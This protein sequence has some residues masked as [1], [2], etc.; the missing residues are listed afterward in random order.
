M[1]REKWGCDKPCEPGQEVYALNCPRCRG[2]RSESCKY[3]DCKNG[4][5][6]QSRCPLSMV[7]KLRLENRVFNTYMLLKK[8]KKF[9]IDGGVLD[10]SATFIQALFG[11]DRILGEL[12]QDSLDRMKTKSK[13]AHRT[14]K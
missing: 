9:P 5:V 1:I 4:V 11:F 10:Q 7:R 14:G 12:E 6:H 3:K 13:Q 2:T 8:Y